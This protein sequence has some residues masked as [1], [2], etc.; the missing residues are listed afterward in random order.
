MTASSK[1]RRPSLPGASLVRPRGP[2]NW[3]K[4][5]ALQKV[6]LGDER[7]LFVAPAAVLSGAGLYGPAR[8]L[9]GLVAAQHVRHGLEPHV[10]RGL[11]GQGRAQSTRAEKHELLVLPERVL[12]VG[13]FR[14]NPEFQ[15]ATR[16]I[17]GAGNLAIT[18]ALARIAQVDQHH[19]VAAKELDGL[20][21]AKLFDLALGGLD[22]GFDTSDYLLS[23]RTSPTRGKVKGPSAAILTLSLRQ[24]PFLRHV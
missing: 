18:L 16:H 14:I 8:L 20:A 4:A 17:E 9:P 5:T 12:V 6:W 2:G 15:H 7:L 1:R 3:Q 24:T 23:H 11:G 19:V 21:G 22:H 13:A 10:L